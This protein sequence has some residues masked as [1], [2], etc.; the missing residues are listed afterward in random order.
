[1]M[2]TDCDLR[3]RHQDPACSRTLLY[4]IVLLQKKDTVSVTRFN[5]GRTLIALL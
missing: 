4:C 5:K 1:M 3:S 2:V